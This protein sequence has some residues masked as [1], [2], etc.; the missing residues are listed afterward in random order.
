MAESKEK[1]TMEKEVAT[2]KSAE[3]IA[4]EVERIGI[5]TIDIDEPQGN[6]LL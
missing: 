5:D 3:K 1:E 6:W 4:Q 2:T